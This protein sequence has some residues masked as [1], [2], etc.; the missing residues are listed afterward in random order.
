MI[1]KQRDKVQFGMTH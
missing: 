1:L